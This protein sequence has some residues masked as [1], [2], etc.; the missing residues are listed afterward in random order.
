V[1]EWIIP[2]MDGWARI[3]KPF[4]FSMASLRRNPQIPNPNKTNEIERAGRLHCSALL[5]RV[6]YN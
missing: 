4:G 3:V 6:S 1:V 5:I 2:I